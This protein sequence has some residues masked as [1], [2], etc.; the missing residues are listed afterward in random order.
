MTL[1][2]MMML[3]ENIMITMVTD[4]SRSA[5]ATAPAVSANG[6]NAQGQVRQYRIAKAHD[7]R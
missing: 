2:V 7:S 3:L 4:I 5:M 1:D 6:N